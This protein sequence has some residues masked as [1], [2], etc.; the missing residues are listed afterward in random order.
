MR[1]RALLSS[2]A[3]LTATSLGAAALGGLAGCA[4]LGGSEYEFQTEQS[5]R[6]DDVPCP[7]YYDTKGTTCGSPPAGAPPS[8][9]TLDGRTINR[10]SSGGTVSATTATLENGLG[11]AI[12]IPVQALQRYTGDEWRHVTGWSGDGMKQVPAGG[13]WQWSL[14]VRQHPTPTGVVPV[15]HDF[16]PGVWA[17]TVV[18]DLAP[19]EERLADVECSAVFTVIESG[20]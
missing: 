7:N 13:T 9:L 18:V 17:Y 16:A 8:S 5:S 20:D 1:R 14:S 6:L 19:D 4:A 11:R 12:G 10:N 3:T 2:T 15:V